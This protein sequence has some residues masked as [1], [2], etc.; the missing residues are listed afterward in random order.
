MKYITALLVWWN[1]N[2][3]KKEFYGLI[4]RK[5]KKDWVK[6]LRSGE[7]RQGKRTLVKGCWPDT[8]EYCCLGVLGRVC[9]LSVDNM[10][11]HTSFAD[12]YSDIWS[13]IPEALLKSGNVTLTNKL[14]DMNDMQMKSFSEIADWIEENL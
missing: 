6:A 4:S 2:I 9:G 7:Y 12:H 3:L 5:L 13:S 10:V 11:N 14:I 1:R 8:Q